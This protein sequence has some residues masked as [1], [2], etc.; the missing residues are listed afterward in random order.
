MNFNQI[1]EKLEEEIKGENQKELI[2]E[3]ET[4]LSK[5]I[6]ELSKNENFFK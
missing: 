2:N 1:V 3:Y 4:K 6:E 5:E